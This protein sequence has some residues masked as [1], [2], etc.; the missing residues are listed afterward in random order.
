MVTINQGNF[1]QISIKPSSRIE[2][3][4][5]DKKD[6]LMLVTFKNNKKYLYKGVSEDLV[7]KLTSAD[8]LGKAFQTLVIHAG[9]D[10]DK[11]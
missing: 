8:S 4:W 7:E 3:L 1:K 6:S 10:Y 9:L 2:D 5:Y 11:L